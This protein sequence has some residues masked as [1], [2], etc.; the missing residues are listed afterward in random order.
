M[1]EISAPIVG[2][3]DADL[4]AGPDAILEV[5]RRVLD[6][7]D[8]AM[9]SRGLED[10]ILE[11]RQPF[12]RE[13]AGKVFNLLLRRLAKIP[14]RDT[15]CGLKLFRRDVAAAIFQR[16]RLDGFAFDV[17]IVA[18]ALALGYSVEEVPIRWTHVEKS[19][20][21]IVRDPLRMLRDVLKVVRPLRYGAEELGIPSQ[22]A[23]NQMIDTEEHHW[24]HVAKR[25]L[26]GQTVSR[27]AKSPCLDVGCGGGRMVEAVG[28]LMPS[29]G[30][31]LS[32][33]ALAAAREHGV[34]GLVRAEAANLPFED[35]TFGTVLALDVIEHHP[36]PELV[37][38]EVSRVLKDDGIVVVTVPAFDW[39]W[40]HTDRALG[41]YRRYTRGG[42]LHELEGA[43]L[44]VDRATYFHSWLLIVA[45][46]FRR[47]RALV[48]RGEGADDFLPPPP[49]N[50][51][52]LGVARLERRLLARFDLPFGL[53][54]VAIGRRRTDSARD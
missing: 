11:V 15:Q 20:V 50:R 32:P 47:L 24:W 17:E 34:D 49:I 48:G 42:L 36:Q 8:M 46:T 14:H 1:L 28:R 4:S 7:A 44:K 40:S 41:H 21:S 18:L 5:Y 27:Y 3:V 35:S 53:S 33:R 12:Y 31:E 25:E 19:R 29:F 30:V 23:L 26:V 9:G 51:L 39:M 38:T 22:P 6:G 2:Y 37:L 52:L 13:R 16:Q 10:S 54:V 45:W 43:R